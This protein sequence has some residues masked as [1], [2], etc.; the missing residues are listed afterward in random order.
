[1][2]REH[3][4]ARKKR[5]RKKG[6]FFCRCE[7]SRFEIKRAT[8]LPSDLA[9]IVD[10]YCPKLLVLCEIQ[11]RRRN[12]VSE[13]RWQAISLQNNLNKTIGYQWHNFASAVGAESWFSFM[14]FDCGCIYWMKCKQSC[15]GWRRVGDGHR[16]CYFHFIQ[17]VWGVRYEREHDKTSPVFR[18][19]ATNAT[20]GPWDD[21]RLVFCHHVDFDEHKH[22]LVFD[23]RM[24]FLEAK[25]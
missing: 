24:H 11:E 19:K 9:S 21:G 15:L 2:D 5:K 4:N 14:Y 10:S 23:E 1:V 3:G 6:S 18:I 8:Q 17:H 25:R 22:V 20:V 13:K 7:M 12:T 16:L